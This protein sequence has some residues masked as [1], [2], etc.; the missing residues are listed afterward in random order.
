MA[1]KPKRLPI[2]QEVL[3]AVARASHPKVPRS[4]LVEACG[5]LTR[6]HLV[7]EAR[8]HRWRTRAMAAEK[9]ERA[10][11]SKVK[12]LGGPAAM[13]RSKVAALRRLE[14][15]R[16]RLAFQADIAWLKAYRKPKGFLGFQQGGSS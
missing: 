8:A 6:R 15:T 12:G 11:R 4:H 14:R 16:D 7:A 3:A 10:L 13:G 9:A 5:E 2:A 1:R